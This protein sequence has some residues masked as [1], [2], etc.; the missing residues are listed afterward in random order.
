[1]DVP[2]IVL[3]LLVAASMCELVPCGRVLGWGS[4]VIYAKSVANAFI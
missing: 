3:L 1:M 2:D 4:V